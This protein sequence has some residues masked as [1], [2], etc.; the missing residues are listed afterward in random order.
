MGKKFWANLA[1]CVILGGL[2]SLTLTNIS[3]ALTPKGLFVNERKPSLE[4]TAL[5]PDVQLVNYHLSEKNDRMVQ[6]DFL[7]RNNSDQDV[8][9][10]KVRC[11]FYGFHGKYFDRKIWLLSGQVSAGEIMRHNSLSKRFV[12]SLTSNYHCELVDFSF[13]FPPFFVLHRGE[14]GD[15]GHHGF[16]PGH[17]G[18]HAPDDGEQ[19]AH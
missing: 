15:G 9:N 2:A 18:K 3:S 11:E 12:H 1:L 19:A 14:R 6:A 10:I 16:V 17:G 8:K 7:V 13:D 5:L 4:V